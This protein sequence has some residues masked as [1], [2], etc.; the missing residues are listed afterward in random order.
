M[1]PLLRTAR[2]VSSGPFIMESEV[3]LPQQLSTS[4]AAITG[5]C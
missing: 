1:V 5:I 4:E 2:Y 3:D